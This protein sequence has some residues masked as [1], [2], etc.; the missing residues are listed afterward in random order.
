MTAPSHATMQLEA[1]MRK[2]G[3]TFTFEQLFIH[4]S[5]NEDSRKAAKRS[6]QNM[7]QTNRVVRVGKTL[8]AKYTLV[9]AALPAPDIKTRGYTPMTATDWI[10]PPSREG[11]LDYM[12]CPSLIDGKRVPYRPPISGMVTDVASTSKSGLD[13]RRLLF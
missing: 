6:F 2:L 4:A 8:P 12:A 10:D 7:K 5:L 13:A 3:G 11:A 9:C 1:A